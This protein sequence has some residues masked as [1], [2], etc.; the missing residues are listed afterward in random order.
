MP[1]LLY[2]ALVLAE[3]PPALDAPQSED[4][5]IEL[6][7]PIDARPPHA[8]R[9]AARWSEHLAA[10]LD[11]A[12]Q[13]L[14]LSTTLDLGLDWE[15]AP[16]WTVTVAGRLR[17]RVAY[18]PRTAG[19][20][21]AG[22]A[23]AGEA[24]ALAGGLYP[25]V[26]RAVIRWRPGP[27][28]QLGLDCVRLGRS[29]L[30]RPLD[31]LNPIDWRAGPL[32]P[33]GGDRLPVPV[34]AFRNPLGAGELL[35]AWV[36]L[37]IAPHVPIGARADPRLALTPR[38]PLLTAGSL[39]GGPLSEVSDLADLLDSARDIVRSSELALRWTQRLGSLDLALTWLYQRDRVPD[40]ADPSARARQHVLGLDLAL[41]LGPLRTV[42]ELAIIVDQRVWAASPGLPSS[43]HPTLHATLEG[44]ISPA[45]FLDLTVG[46]EAIIDLAGPTSP[47][48]LFG[49]PRDLWVTARLNLLLAFDGVLRL[50][51]E[52]RL[53]LSRDDLVGTL[54][55]TARAR[56]DLEL[57]LGLALFGGNPMD[58]GLGGLY[59][60]LDSLWLRATLEL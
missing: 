44:A 57:T 21:S 7:A 43:R 28:L 41:P 37:F 40:L 48:Y 47:R 51:A 38:S 10:P 22:S 9:A 16:D 54:A 34:V 50:D 13:P 24:T 32:G 27:E 4:E 45:I 11:P 19:G 30:A 17:H 12:S 18:A 5:A 60:S 14:T 29:Q 35:I 20:A 33:E 53:G 8:L 1:L 23:L 36:P 3:P 31:R 46:L 15:P 52:T 6:G 56:P 26:R 59:E 25:E 42:G 39:P 2:V 49:G 58:G 55:L